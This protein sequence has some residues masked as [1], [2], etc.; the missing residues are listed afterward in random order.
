MHSSTS[1]VVWI[2]GA[3]SGIGLA[4]AQILAAEGFKLIVSGRRADR[5][6]QFKTNAP[7]PANIHIADFD[8]RHAQAAQAAFDQLPEAFRQID[9]LIHNAG[10]AH[11]LDP[12]QSGNTDDWDQ[13]IDINIKGILYLSRVVLPGMVERGLGQ[14]ILVGSI[15]GKE[16]YPNGNVYCANKH[17]VDALNKVM[18][19]D[20]Y[21]HGIRV[22][23]VQPGLVET[24]FS[25]VRFKGDAERAEKVYQGYQ[26]LRPEDVADTI[27]YIIHSPPHVNIADVLIL[28]AAQASSGLVH[29]KLPTL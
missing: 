1:K 3:T 9:I 25:L 14:V 17:A 21:Q 11:G 19:M 12:I 28:P 20:L 16:V 6:L 27:R 15:A 22:S 10:N 24:E 23:A 8:I 18:R 13:M 29:K 4:T 2:T 5:L 7:H 26:P